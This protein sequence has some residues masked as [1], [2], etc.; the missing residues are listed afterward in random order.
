MTLFN[1]WSFKTRFSRFRRNVRY[2]S[3]FQISLSKCTDW[4]CFRGFTPVSGQRGIIC[5]TRL[6]STGISHF[7]KKLWIEVPLVP[8]RSLRGL[9]NRE[10]PRR[11]A[12]EAAWAAKESGGKEENEPC[13]LALFLFFLRLLR[14]FGDGWRGDVVR[15]ALRP[16]TFGDAGGCALAAGVGRIA[17]ERGHALADR[18]AESL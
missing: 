16:A 13:R 1:H 10:N 7:S 6:L 2:L 15:H 12:G 9:M 14:R 18:H 5:R 3:S 11:F 4:D 17:G 8:L